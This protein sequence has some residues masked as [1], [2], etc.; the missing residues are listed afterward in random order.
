MEPRTKGSPLIAASLTMS[1]GL[2]A[3]RKGVPQGSPFS[4][5]LANVALTGFDRALDTRDWTVI[6]YADDLAVLC[7]SADDAQKAQKRVASELAALGLTMHP[8][9][10]RIVDSRRESFSFLGVAL[11]PADH[12]PLKRQGFPDPGGYPLVAADWMGVARNGPA[13]RWA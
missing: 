9:K 8:R 12:R 5:L 11:P 1:P 13:R 7:R 10:T 6:R 2:W 3:A 4:P